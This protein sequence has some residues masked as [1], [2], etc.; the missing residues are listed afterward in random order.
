[1]KSEIIKC[2]TARRP[3]KILCVILIPIALFIS[4]IG[5]IGITGLDYA[6]SDFLFADLEKNDYFYDNYIYRTLANA[7]S[8]FW[9]QSEENIR[10]MGCLEWEPV[11]YYSSDLPPNT[12]DNNVYPYDNGNRYGYGNPYDIDSDS[13][14]GEPTQ[15]QIAQYSLR[16]TNRTNQWYFG[17]VNAEHIDSE[18][19]K[20]MVEN[21]IQQQLSEFFYA[22]SQLEEVPGLY[23]FITDGN[24]WVGN[25]SPENNVNFYKS[26]PVYFVNENGKPPEMSRDDGA[27]YQYPYYGG[28][29]SSDNISSYIAFASEAV[30]WQNNVW[31]TAQRQL[32]IQLALIAGP[33]VAALALFVILLVGAGRRYG[34]ES[35]KV[36]FM[37]IDKPWLDIGLCLVI[38]YEAVL[39]YVIYQALE[40]AGRYD[41]AKWLTILF[42]TASVV[43]TLP[44]LWWITSLVKLCKAGKFWRHT[45]CYM[46]LRGIFNGVK[47]IL[48][49][50]WA[51][52]RLT[53]RVALIGF[54]L[55]IA[56]IICF[57]FAATGEPAV[58]L[59]LCFVFSAFA[60]FLLLRYARKIQNS[61]R[62]RKPQ[63]EAAMTSPSP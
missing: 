49:S 43:L 1:M 24:R 8:V 33:L 60:V 21:A 56:T 19:T 11:A 15:M 47:K 26:N 41:N 61:N 48:K 36:S 20:Q 42:A 32:E 3:V 4:S 57:G 51:G 5:I 34:F 52:A 28:Y 23:Y 30:N 2:W 40:T 59:F 6:S 7:E 46:I 31:K 27:P 16:S 37:T 58:G 9:L 12:Y 13:P 39:G 22:K 62:A 45:M 44:A 18:E 35:G 10:N 55:L 50:L 29:Y 38:G 17:T 53:V 14:V 25:V 54:A 63:A